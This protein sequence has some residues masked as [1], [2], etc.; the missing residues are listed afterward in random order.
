MIVT[1]SSGMPHAPTA[2]S[3][4]SWMLTA[5]GVVDSRE[6]G[7]EAVNPEVLAGGVAHLGDAVG[8]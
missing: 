3:K 8:I 5:G 6:F 7:A 2:S 4:C 1:S